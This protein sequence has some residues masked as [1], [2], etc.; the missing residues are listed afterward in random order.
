M[1][2]TLDDVLEIQAWTFIL[3]GGLYCLQE[4]SN[5]LSW[6]WKE[7]KPI[8]VLGMVPIISQGLLLKSLYDLLPLNHDH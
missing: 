6:T 5:P 7:M 3:V 4:W 1:I 2:I 8:V